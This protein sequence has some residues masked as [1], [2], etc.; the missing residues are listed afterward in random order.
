ML[1][2]FTEGTCHETVDETGDLL[3][4]VPEA[5]SQVA[6]ADHA[7]LQWT[8]FLEPLCWHNSSDIA[9]L[10]NLIVG[11]SLNRSPFQVS[12]FRYPNCNLLALLRRTISPTNA[13]APDLRG[14]LR[15]GKLSCE[16][17]AYS[18]GQH[19]TSRD[20]GG[21]AM[22]DDIHSIRVKA[23]GD[24]LRSGRATDGND[25]CDCGHNCG[26]DAVYAIVLGKI[27][28]ERGPVVF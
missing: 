26:S 25:L 5:D 14:Y 6:T 1:W 17:H 20:A 11:K 24:D 4:T 16:C 7:R 18:G 8:R 28:R 2:L 9:E 19:D 22:A 23:L 21:A 12:I 3:G 15:E 27:V 10:R 13:I